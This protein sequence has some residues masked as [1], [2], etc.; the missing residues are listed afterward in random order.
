MK[1][2]FATCGILLGKDWTGRAEEKQVRLTGSAIPLGV[3][4]LIA[5]CASGL[6]Q[7]LQPGPASC[8]PYLPP[9]T[10]NFYDWD[11]IGP[12][13]PCYLGEVTALKS[14]LASATDPEDVS[15]IRADLA[16]IYS[17][18]GDQDQSEFWLRPLE[19]AEQKLSEFVID[20]GISTAAALDYIVKAA[21]GFQFVALNESHT[22]PRHRDFA[23]RLLKPLKDQGF[24]YFAAEAFT[25]DPAE[26]SESIASGAPTFSSGYY[27]RDPAF[28]RL[29]REALELGFV[30][31]PYEASEA[32]N[33]PSPQGGRAYHDYRESSQA[34][35]L[36]DR[37]LAKDPEA[38][39]FI[40]AGYSH[41]IEEP[42][43]ATNGPSPALWMAGELKALSNKDILTIDQVS[44][45]PMARPE[46]QD[47][48]YS[49]IE[50]LIEGAEHVVVLRDG[51][52]AGLGYYGNKVDL[53][54]AHARMPE[55]QGRPGWM[56]SGGG[57]RWVEVYAPG[58]G[59]VQLKH[60]REP[61]DAIPYDQML[62]DQS[63][64]V[65]L[66]APRSARIKS[67]FVAKP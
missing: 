41:I 12:R 13:D 57:Q 23:R 7:T 20:E 34:K 16:T 36:F 44:L 5:A 37:T 30:L 24:R 62:V 47:P 40:Y 61:E 3:L 18:M 38:K 26:F 19:D 67:E 66:L 1:T 4:A 64:P 59:L 52:P 39:V 33:G 22:S 55:N 48:D 42:V 15:D 49:M 28:G 27:L 21:S 14:F 17:E 60:I 54:V 63:G 8:E 58:P 50:P 43:V 32:V 2:L 53:V 35:N 56:I 9:A 6:P 29:V 25:A 10:Y 65:F 11:V 46:L 51:R 45:S 31:V